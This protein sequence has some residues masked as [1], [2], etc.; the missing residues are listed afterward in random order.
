[1]RVEPPKGNE[2]DELSGSVVTDQYLNR[3]D[4]LKLLRPVGDVSSSEV[5]DLL[6]AA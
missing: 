2:N 4:A 6:A 5:R 1:M 3:P